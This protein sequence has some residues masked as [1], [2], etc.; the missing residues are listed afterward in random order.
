M[1][2]ARLSILT[3]RGPCQSLESR[4]SQRL[5]LGG[6]FYTTA[7]RYALAGMDFIMPV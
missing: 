6:L 2:V 5:M 4:F 3:P 7:V 1:L